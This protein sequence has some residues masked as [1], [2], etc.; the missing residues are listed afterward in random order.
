MKNLKIAQK[1]I[2][3]YAVILVMMLVIVFFSTSILS[4]LNTIID[5][6]YHSAVNNVMLSSNVNA[7]TQEGAKN[8]L[9]AIGKPNDPEYVQEYFD[10]AKEA[11]DNAK[12]NLG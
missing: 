3:G 11:L 7:Y 2:V 10:K 8:I 4:S 5:N 1:L 6:L 9:H 12:K